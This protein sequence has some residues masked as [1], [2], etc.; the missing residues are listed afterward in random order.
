[1]NRSSSAETTSARLRSDRKA[2]ILLPVALVAIVATLSCRSLQYCHSRGNA[3][4]G[5]EMRVG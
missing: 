5:N 1:M 3:P 2:W 4:G